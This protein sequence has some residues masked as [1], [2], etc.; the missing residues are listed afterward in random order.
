LESRL[1][2]R[3]AWRTV[4]ASIATLALKG[5][6]EGWDVLILSGDKDILQL[7]ND[8]I[9]VRDEVRKVEYDAA[10]VEKKYGIKHNNIAIERH[11]R[12]TKR[13]VKLLCHY[14]SRGSH[15]RRC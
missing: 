1:R 8:R 3:V 12:H 5:Y 4:R 7:V 14:K 9:R 13:K 10:Q 15:F 6:G 11:N 2:T